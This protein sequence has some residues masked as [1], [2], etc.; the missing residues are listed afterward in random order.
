LTGGIVINKEKDLKRN[1][2]I[3]DF[4]N[5]GQLRV[6]V[7]TGIVAQQ[8][9]HF[10]DIYAKLNPKIKKLSKKLSEFN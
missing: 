7:I 8:K 3:E 5:D 6:M 10:E 2:E 9:A 4:R 1:L